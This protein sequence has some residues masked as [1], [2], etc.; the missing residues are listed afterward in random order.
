MLYSFFYYKNRNKMST[1]Y[2]SIS[3]T[4]GGRTGHTSTDDNVI[5]LNLSTPESMGGKGEK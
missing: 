3:T 4:V 5:D 2:E 1:L